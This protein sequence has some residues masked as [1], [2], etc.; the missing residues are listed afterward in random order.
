MELIFWLLVGHAICD[1]TFQTDA[2]AKG[3]NRHNKTEPP[4]NQ[5]Y[6]P[7]WPYWLSAHALIH[8][9]SVAL[10][11]GSTVLGLAEFVIHWVTDF[12]KCDNLFGV[13]TDQA[14]HIGSKLAYVLILTA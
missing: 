1:F 7:C 11:T 5:K 13:N 2:M 14:I 4:P 10:V 3:K 12:F 8:A 9:G 6:M